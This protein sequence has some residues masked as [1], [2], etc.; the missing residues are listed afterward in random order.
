LL[1]APRPRVRERAPL[2]AGRCIA[3]QQQGLSLLRTA[4]NLGPRCGAPR[5]PLLF[6]EMIGD[7]GRF[8]LAKAEVFQ[9]LGDVEDIIERIFPPTQSV[10]SRLKS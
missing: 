10:R 5:L 8:L 3:K 6:I 7:K 9:Q 2:R 1:A 4:Q